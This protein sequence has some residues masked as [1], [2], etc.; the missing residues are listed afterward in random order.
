MLEQQNLKSGQFEAIFFH[1]ATL[2]V[3]SSAYMYS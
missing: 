1:P 2:S 3:V